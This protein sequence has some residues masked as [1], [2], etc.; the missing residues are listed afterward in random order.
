MADEMQD[1]PSVHRY[2]WRS[3][4]EW[5]ITVTTWTRVPLTDVDGRVHLFDVP[6]AILDAERSA[7]VPTDVPELPVPEAGEYIEQYRAR[8]DVPGLR[9]PCVGEHVWVEPVDGAWTCVDCGTVT[10]VDDDEDVLWLPA[11]SGLLAAAKRASAFLTHLA[12]FDARGLSHVECGGEPG[13]HDQLAV[14]AARLRAALAMDGVAARSALGNAPA[15]PTDVPGLRERVERE[16]AGWESAAAASDHDSIEDGPA[17][18]RGVRYAATMLRAALASPDA[19]RVT[20]DREALR[21]ALPA[22]EDIRRCHKEAFVRW[23]EWHR[24]ERTGGM[25]FTGPDG[26]MHEA[27]RSTMTRLGLWCANA[28]AALAASQPVPTEPKRGEPHD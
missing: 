23:A 25:T 16:L 13:R 12:D 19:P 7:P 21:E 11:T 26:P 18:A 27:M 15:L 1:G 2:G 17:F 9:E 4:D 6:T 22:L 24:D 3:P 10:P 5:P 8:T 28:A 20:P 14:E